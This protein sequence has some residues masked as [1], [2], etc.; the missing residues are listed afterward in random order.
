VYFE[1]LRISCYKSRQASLSFLSTGLKPGPHIPIEVLVPLL[2]LGNAF[3][4]RLPP[5][6][7]NGSAVSSLQSY[8]NSIQE[9]SLRNLTKESDSFKAFEDIAA[10]LLVEGRIFEV[11]MDEAGCLLLPLGSPSSSSK[12]PGEWRKIPIMDDIFS[13]GADDAVW[14]PDEPA[15]NMKLRFKFRKTAWLLA[16]AETSQ[17]MQFCLGP[18]PKTQFCLCLLPTATGP[19]AFEYQRVGICRFRCTLLDMRQEGKLAELTLV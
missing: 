12:S 3:P 6:L 2:P 11:V 17:E 15:R 7:S 9:Y 4:T 10:R 16:V 14:F 13:L 8:Y 19:T 18:L 1:C 5:N